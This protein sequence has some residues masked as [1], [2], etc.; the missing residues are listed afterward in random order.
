[1][2]TDIIRERAMHPA[3]WQTTAVNPSA[4]RSE[5]KN[6]RMSA[7]AALRLLVSELFIVT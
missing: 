7:V 6:Y 5:E 1:M 2:L 4:V 3:K